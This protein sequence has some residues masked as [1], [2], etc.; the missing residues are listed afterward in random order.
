MIKN[1]DYRDKYIGNTNVLD[2]GYEKV[3]KRLMYFS[4]RRECFDE[5]VLSNMLH[6]ILPETLRQSF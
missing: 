5:D 6:T 4:P 2:G 3:T 1:R